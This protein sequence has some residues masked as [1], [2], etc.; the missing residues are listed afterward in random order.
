[1]KPMPPTPFWAVPA[2]KSPVIAPIGARVPAIFIP[3]RK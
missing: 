1:M 3:V 2:S